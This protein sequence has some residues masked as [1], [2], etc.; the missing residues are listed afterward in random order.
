VGHR[1]CNTAERAVTFYAEKSLAHGRVRF[2]VSPRHSLDEIDRDASLS[3][4]PSGEFLRRRTRGFFYGD[5]PEIGAPTVRQPLSI[6]RTPFWESLSGEGTRS[7]VYYTL[8]AVG[9]LIALLGLANLAKGRGIGWLPF[10]LGLAIA[11]VPIVLTATKRRQIRAQEAKA[12]AEREDRE[13]RERERLDAYAHALQIVRENPT[14]E[15]LEAALQER[16]NLEVSYK[17][18]VPLAKRTVLHIGF[19]ALSRLG[20]SR[21][22]EVSDLMSHAAEKVGLERADASDVKL[23]LYRVLTWHLLADDR[24]GDTQNAQLESLRSGLGVSQ[25]RAPLELQAIDEFNRLRGIDRDNLPRQ[26][27]DMKLAF[28]EYCI[29]STGGKLFGERSN[30]IGSGT[31]Y[32]T[33]KRLVVGTRK[34]ID[35]PLS[36]IDDVEVDLDTHRMTITV[37]RPA[38]PVILQVEQPIYTAA[39]IDIATTLDERQKG[40]T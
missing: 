6:D 1:G 18:W 32:L 34:A 39:L 24:L 19:D 22:K 31:V 9:V 21:A 29:H 8:M 23:D 38:K 30:E 40:F 2:G 16:Q 36:Q 33:N 12:R 14:D 3:T 17:F 25:E 15:N 26:N 11:A 28:H 5:K 13:R 20:P 4:G 10:L 7:I 35:I 27:C 37:A